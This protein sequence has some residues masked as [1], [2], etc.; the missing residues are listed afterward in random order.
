MV[1]TMAT[2][3]VPG[4]DW[5]GKEWAFLSLLAL[6]TNQPLVACCSPPVVSH[7]LSLL[8]DISRLLLP[9]SVP[10]ISCHRPLHRPRCVHHRLPFTS[11]HCLILA[12]AVAATHRLL[13]SVVGCLP[14]SFVTCLPSTC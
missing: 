11:C 3:L 14:P 9:S 4:S 12:A 2:Q 13:S 6:R 5:P 10:A 1:V 7:R 8:P